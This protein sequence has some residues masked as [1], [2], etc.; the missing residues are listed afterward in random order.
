M[1]LENPLSKTITLWRYSVADEDTGEGTYTKQ[2]IKAYVYE[3]DMYS[4]NNEK[5]NFFK[6]TRIITETKIDIRDKITLDT[7]TETNIDNVVR[8]NVG[9]VNELV[10]ENGNV[11]GYEAI[12]K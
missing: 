8:F 4:Y 6:N 11:L 2:E 3:K 9:V 5:V 12:L 1:I 10:D 7:T